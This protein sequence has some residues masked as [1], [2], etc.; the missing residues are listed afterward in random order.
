MEPDSV[1]TS[2]RDSY[3]G[4]GYENPLST[5]VTV[6]LNPSSTGPISK[7]DYG[8]D[9]LIL[10]DIGADSSEWPAVDLRCFIV[11]SNDDLRQEMAL[12]QL[13]C[14]CKEIFEDMGLDDQLFLK[15]Y[16]I[17]GT[18][19]TTGFV[20]VLHDAMSI[21]ALKKTDG[22]T[23]LPD[24]F[25]KTYGSSLERLTKAKRAFT[26]SLAAYSIFSYIL[27][28]KDRHNGNVLIDTEGH[29]IHIDFGFLLGIAPGGAF[30][31]EAAPFKLTEEMV[32]VMDGLESPLF[33][34]FVKAFTTGFLALRS[35]SENI[36]SALKLLSVDSPFPCFINKDA[37]AIID[38]LRSRFRHDLNV[39]EFVQHC[40]D[41]IVASYGHYGT[42]QYDNFQWYTNGIAI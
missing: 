40:L 36:I 29:V 13:L 5:A 18:S 27:L 8:G 14:L 6:T 2:P 23:T 21:D 16:R 22:F 39:K 35:N 10:P 7:D 19:S 25:Q 32:D 41:L 31:L 26:S 11:K 3:S 34:E 4:G 37:N 9:S 28:I 15:S 33:G 1:P 24:Y 12:M 20:E 42:R 38:K 17:V 30:S